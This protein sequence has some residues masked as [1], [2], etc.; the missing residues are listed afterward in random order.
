MLKRH[1]ERR[2]GMGRR[3]RKKICWKCGCFCYDNRWW[4]QKIRIIVGSCEE[5]HRILNP[6]CNSC[7]KEKD[8]GK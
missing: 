1:S 4:N 8:C 7:R 6:H 3:G 2:D 5:L